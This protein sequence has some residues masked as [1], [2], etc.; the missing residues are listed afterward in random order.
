MPFFG[1]DYVVGC[2]CWHATLTPYHAKL[3]SL[4]P[5]QLTLYASSLP[6][7]ILS[8]VVISVAPHVPITVVGLACFPRLS[9]LWF[10]KLGEKISTIGCREVAMHPALDLRHES[11][12]QWSCGLSVSVLLSASI[13]RVEAERNNC[14]LAT[15]GKWTRVINPNHV[16]ESLINLAVEPPDL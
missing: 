8:I 9:Q 16:A 14:R 15:I 2:I 7:S 4:V 5:S 3:T 11:T 13:D 12:Y 1:H 6:T 10:M